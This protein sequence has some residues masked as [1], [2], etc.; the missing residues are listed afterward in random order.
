MRAYTTTQKIIFVC[1]IF[2]FAGAL[3]FGAMYFKRPSN[4][5]QENVRQSTT[6]PAGNNLPIGNSFPIYQ[7]EAVQTLNPNAEF[8]KQV[9]PEVL[10]KSKIELAELS[11]KLQKQ[12][13]SPQDWFR[14][15]Y[16]KH[17][18]G[19]DI[20]AR[21]AYLYLIAIKPDDAISVYNVAVLFGYYL[22][23]SK[24]AIAYFE[25]VLRLDPRNESF[26]LG[27]AD[28]YRDAE[29]DVTLT[30]KVLLT[31]LTSLPGNV[32]L[33]SALAG[34]YALMGRFDL[35]ISYYERVLASGGLTASLQESV[36]TE[37]NRLKA[38]E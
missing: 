24:Q 6:T 4:R 25:R 13:N 8:L 11:E 1:G 14:V 36:T 38:K 30:E 33:M 35:A 5:I 32:N 26:Y 15:A 29:K 21:D 7:G 19:D 9:P 2:L 28:F 10:E 37:L 27:F 17:F 34:N 18:Y 22:H 20:G 16:I 31:G 12:P 23:D 3:T